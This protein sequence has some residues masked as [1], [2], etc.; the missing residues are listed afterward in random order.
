MSHAPNS[1]VSKL[2]KSAF[3]ATQTGDFETARALSLQVLSTDTGNLAALHIYFDSTKIKSGDPIFANLVQFCENTTLPAKIRSELFFML[4][5]GFADQ[6]ATTDAFNAFV[7]ANKLAGKRGDPNGTSAL[8]KSLIRHV[9]VL[10]TRPL[11][12]STTR[13][14]FILGMPRS[15]TSIMAQ[16]LACHTNVLSLGENTGLG[17]AMGAAGW[18]DLSLD[19]LPAFFAQITPAVLADIRDRYLASVNVPYDPAQ[20]VLVDKM[21]ENYWFAWIIPLIFPNAQIVHMK[22]QPLANCWSC[23]RHDFKDGHHYAYDFKTMMAQYAI[24]AETVAKWRELS[25][26][27]WHETP[28][29]TFVSDPRAV[30]EPVLK[31]LDLGWQ[32]ACL[33]PE[34]NKSAVSTLSKW[35]VRQGLDRKISDGWKAYLPLI[36]QRFLS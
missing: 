28:L 18:T 7:Q 12:P 6:H 34:N 23:F 14:I 21:P 35:Q 8:S 27:N 9:N 19:H 1:T 17:G 15:G 33:S 26:N 10:Q 22:R 29:D 30:I 4:G 24:Y 11:A 5:K 13:M 31:N 25:P 32:D 3:L 20:T 36:K 16:S 2:V